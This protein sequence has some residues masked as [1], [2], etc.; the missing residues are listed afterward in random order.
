[1]IH[2]LAVLL[3]LNSKGPT[4]PVNTLLDVNN[5]DVKLHSDAH[6]KYFTESVDAVTEVVQLSAPEWVRCSKGL[7]GL[8]GPLE[9]RGSRAVR[10][11]I[12]YGQPPA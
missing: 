6:S 11:C 1:M 4:E 12:T 2:C 7:T 3:P 8:D 9:W 5:Q 10:Q